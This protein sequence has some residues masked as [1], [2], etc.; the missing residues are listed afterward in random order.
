MNY[1]GVRRRSRGK[2]DSLRCRENFFC[3][4]LLCADLIKVSNFFLASLLYG[5]EKVSTYFQ[6]RREVGLPLLSQWSSV[7]EEPFPPSFWR[8]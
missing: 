6:G 2:I 1:E 7:Q 5:R 4:V 3:R 8:S